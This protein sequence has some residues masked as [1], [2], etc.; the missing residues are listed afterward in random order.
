[1]ISCQAF[2]ISFRIARRHIKWTE[3]AVWLCIIV[4]TLNCT[5]CGYTETHDTTLAINESAISS[6][7]ELPLTNDVNKAQDKNTRLLRGLYSNYDYAYSVLI[8]DGLN[9][10]IP[11]PP[12]PN[13]G[14]NITLFDKPKSYLWVDASYNASE[15][16]S[17]NDVVKA[18]TGYVKDNGGTNIRVVQQSPTQLSTLKAV[19]FVIQ[20]EDHVSNE[21]V[22]RDVIFAFRREQGGDEINYEIVLIAPVSRYD[23]DKEVVI[24]LQKTWRLGPLPT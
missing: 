16:K 22:M 5:C 6:N 4:L 15:W 9:A 18:H 1:M 23:E 10:L 17:Y 8:P 13:H 24:E 12:L 11:A 2:I 14:F 20:Y 19:H 7:V 21:L 3:K